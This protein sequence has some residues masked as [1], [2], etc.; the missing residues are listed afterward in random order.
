MANGIIVKG[1]G[2]GVDE[3]DSSAVIDIASTA[4][5]I[6]IPRM[7]TIQRDAISS[8]ATGLKI[9]NATSGKENVYSGV[10]WEEVVSGESSIWSGNTTDDTPTEIFIGGVT[11]ARFGIQAQSSSDF[12]LICF[13]RN[14]SDN[15]KKVMYISDLVK[16]DLNRKYGKGYIDNVLLTVVNYWFK[17]TYKLEVKEVE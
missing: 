11:N 12:K 6:L 17:K 1:L 2:I 9:F 13:A 5:G 16:F 3:I 4:S 8:P 15:K 14:N 7:T 10:S